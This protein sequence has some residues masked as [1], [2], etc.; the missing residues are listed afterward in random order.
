MT[1]AERYPIVC[2]R[3]LYSTTLLILKI[4]IWFHIE[5]FLHGT[6]P[7]S[8]TFTV[9]Q[10]WVP[11]PMNHHRFI[12][13]NPWYHSRH[14]N[15][16]HES[17]EEE[18][19]EDEDEYMLDSNDD[20]TSLSASPP[21]FLFQSSNLPSFGL[22]RG[23][24]APAHRKA[25]SKS[26]STQARIY[27]CSNCAAEYVNWVGKCHTCQKYNT[28][29]EFFITRARDS[30]RTSSLFS[31][32][33]SV[34][35]NH[36]LHPTN[37]LSEPYKSRPTS[38]TS[39][40][41]LSP[42]YESSFS[43]TLFPN[44]LIPM[45]EILTNT[46][47]P[48]S[49]RWIIPKDS[50][51]N[52]VLGGG[53]VPGSLIL[54]GGDPG[55]GKSTLLL[56]TAFQMASSTTTHPRRIVWYISGEETALQIASRAQRLGLV[57][58]KDRLH[59]H[60]MSKQTSSSINMTL[61]Q[62]NLLLLTETN[63]DIIVQTLEQSISLNSVPSLILV[64]SIQTMYCPS[65]TSSS[66]FTGSIAQVRECVS[67]FLQ[68]AKSTQIPIILIG[69]VTKQGDV[70]GP[71]TVEHLVDAV[72]YLEQSH[73]V[74]ILRAVKNRFGSVH[75]VG[76]Y[77]RCLEE[78]SPGLLMPV[79]DPSNLFLQE[80]NRRKDVQGCAVS[81]ALEGQRAMAIEIQALVS[82]PGSVYS[83]KSCI[84]QGIS[85]SRVYL[86][87]AILSK[88]YHIHLTRYDIYINIVGGF[89]GLERDFWSRG[90]TSSDLAVAITLM[91]SLY[92]IPIRSDTA[93][94]GE[95]GILGELRPVM[96]MERRFAEAVRMG[97][98]RI[99]TPKVH[100]AKH[101]GWNREDRQYG[102]GSMGMEHLQFE[103][104]EEAIEAGLVRPIQVVNRVQ[105]TI[106]TFRRSRNKRIKRS[107]PLR[108]GDPEDYGIH[109]KDKDV[110]I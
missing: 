58:P 75:E 15:Q 60:R 41:S 11:C 23:R 97:F 76:I 30:I 1:A 48:L 29:Q 55:V 73:Q 107:T 83:R 49:F 104:V 110:F 27:S 100:R 37:T 65:V 62:Q 47:D 108:D 34:M 42:S 4:S 59:M 2:R 50:E 31:T 103:N 78:P 102:I 61:S 16:D 81:L 46:T 91:S 67:I 19:D 21:S 88:L 63:M 94:V 105:S 3:R 39:F 6:L 79:S 18:E 13:I 87:M 89:R 77:E 38:S 71:K 45:D 35:N 93:F 68:L 52:T 101:G 69:H 86:I 72:L 44:H 57:Q 9:I 70:A 22:L 25:M 10:A 56:Q 51:F 26:S 17:E 53:L 84:V 54:L 95:I 28:V 106:P 99:I 7:S 74:L 32:P 90:S 64:D 66:S 33:N 109:D 96:D 5:T 85:Q 92:Q 14:P 43:S 20:N 12:H 24:S 80:M 98:S 40:E 8:T 82:S 36:H